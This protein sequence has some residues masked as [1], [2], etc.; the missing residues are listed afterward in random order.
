MQTPR[1]IITETDSFS[2]GVP[3]AE[4]NAVR[5]DAELTELKLAINALIWERGNSSLTLDKAD[6]LAVEI[7]DLI[8]NAK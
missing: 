8:I 5:T 4:A 1:P 7:M 6:V 2:S 3:D